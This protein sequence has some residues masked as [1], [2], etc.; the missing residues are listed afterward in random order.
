MNTVEELA[1]VMCGVEW[2]VHS[3][4]LVSNAA[5][6]RF[7]RL[8]RAVLNSPALHEIYLAGFKS[9]GEGFNGEYSNSEPEQV[10]YWV[11]G[12]DEYFKSLTC[13]HHR[14]D[15]IMNLTDPPTVRSMICRDCKKD[16]R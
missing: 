3:W 5:R 7:M 8:A 1:K 15:T 4:P 9:A 6:R 2:G 12:R 13:E 10:E 11:K 14:I 16:M